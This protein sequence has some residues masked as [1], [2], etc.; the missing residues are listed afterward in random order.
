MSS[1]LELVEEILKRYPLCDHCLG[2]LFARYGRGLSNAERGRALKT[3]LLINLFAR[4]GSNR[5][6]LINDLREL[7]S[8][9]GEPFK[10][11]L[12]K[13]SGER[14]EIAECYVC[15]SKI[16]EYINEYSERVERILRREGLSR[17]VIGVKIPREMSIR[18]EELARE[19]RIDS[20]ESIKSELKREVG[21]RVRDKGFTPDFED[22]EI[23]INIDLST[24]AIITM[25]PSMIYLVRVAKLERGYRLRRREG[26]LEDLLNKK[27]GIYEPEYVKLHLL[28]R[29]SVRYKIYEPGIYGLIE[30]KSPRRGRPSIEDLRR[31]L[32]DL[33]PFKISIISRA[34]R[35]D[36]NNL[37]QRI[38][39]V[40][41]EIFAL[42]RKSLSR[43]D[44]EKIF[45]NKIST[46]IVTQ[47]TPSRFLERGYEEKT[48]V[49]QVVLRELSLEN[50]MLRIILQMDKI[51]FPEEFVSGD[52]GRTEPSLAS[53]LGT[54]LEILE[55]NIIDMY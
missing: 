18:E 41:Y 40:V 35:K 27:L 15:G 16:N 37:S 7:A 32:S 36:I 31:L 5:D 33:Y 4:H 34:K 47:K 3:A 43:E 9:A 52:G 23:I 22:P 54:E 53:L 8:R 25:Y 46:L 39:H 13:I 12:E 50:N 10:T 26:S 1:V 45:F 14:I 6:L 11:S 44:L 48:R 51:L 28:A 24:G 49:G 19:F 55:V 20:W 38:T 21:K 30:I 29:D 42:P 2:R 17:F